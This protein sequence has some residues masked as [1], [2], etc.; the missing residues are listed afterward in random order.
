MAASPPSLLGLNSTE[1]GI[2]GVYPS[3]I[4]ADSAGELFILGCPATS[5]SPNC[6]TKLSAD[7]KTI[8]WQNTL[9]FPAVMA[10]DPSGGVYL[11]SATFD[12]PTVFVEKLSADGSTVLWKTQL[13][14]LIGTNDAAGGAPAIAVDSTGR[15]FVTGYGLNGSVVGEYVMR[16][17]AAGAVDYS[18]SLNGLQPA[19]VAIAVDPTGSYVSVLS[20]ALAQLSPSSP[21]WVYSTVPPIG[22]ASTMNLA[23][24]PNGD[25]VLY[26][27][28]SNGNWSL[29]RVHPSGAVVFSEA[30]PSNGQTLGVPIQLGLALDAAGN[31]YIT[32]FNG[33]L[34]HPVLNTLAPCGQ[35]WLSMYAPDG[36]L[37]QSTYIPGAADIGPGG[38]D[39]WALI[40][41]SANS[42][43]VLD[44]AGASF[45]PTQTG[46]FPAPTT[47]LASGLL[48]LGPSAGVVTFPLACVGNAASYVAGPVAPGE[49]ATLFGNALGPLQ[50]VQT[51]ATAQS[52]FPK[53]AV[54]VEVTFDGTPAPLLW[55][56]ASQINVVVP[57]SVAGP[58]T[59]I[60]AT[61]N[62]PL[63]N[64]ISTTCL[65]WPVA[66]TAPG[67]FTTDG[68][69]AAAMN[70]DE[71]VNSASNPAPTGSIVSVFATGLGLIAPPQADGSLVELPLPA[72]VLPL[73]LQP[74]C[75]GQVCL[76]LA[77]PVLYGGPAPF[78]IAGASQIN[79]Q[80]IS[81]ET[82]LAVAVGQAVSNGFR[83]YVAGQ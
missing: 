17:N 52:P 12:E 49:I 53:Q 67:V 20:S 56:Q 57:W 9:D 18:T 44:S 61:Y 35:A 55:V 50:G 8:L 66:Q 7:G 54:G 71:T 45:A 80:A 75:A 70:Q 82:G 14:V 33:T 11:V 78:L 65:T 25:T 74:P 76:P 34:M 72:N 73:L 48:S 23:I 63:T 32:G 16:L 28:D 46:P 4:A 5:P 77:F 68:I 3:Q 43:Y 41:T 40:S 10:V 13:D 37:V 62:P 83:V 39:F 19:P 22:A 1:W 6:V 59:R 27:A 38:A 64:V 60:C 21:T 42:V 79:F 2:P 24:A 31:E 47:G 36:S 69:H 30:T 51:D 58:T 15:T 81:S 26:D 29:E